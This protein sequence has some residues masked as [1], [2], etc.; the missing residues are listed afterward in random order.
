MNRST[1]AGMAPCFIG[2][3]SKNR[4]EQLTQ[5]IESLVHNGLGSSTTPRLRRIA[6]HPVFRDI[7]VQTAQI[8]GTKLVE[9]LINLMK[10]ECFVSRSTISNH[11]IKPLQNPAIDQCEI[12]C[13]GGL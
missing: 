1:V 10:L 11:L 13:S 9:C 6:I 4:R 2:G 5:R 8:D 7:D 3:K 12:F